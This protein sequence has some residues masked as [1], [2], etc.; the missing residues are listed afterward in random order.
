[1]SPDYGKCPECG[2]DYLLTTA[3]VLRKHVH[4]RP[5]QARYEATECPGSGRYPAGRAS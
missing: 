4:R 5:G 2:K 3:G 1:M